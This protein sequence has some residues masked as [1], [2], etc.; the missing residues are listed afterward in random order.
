MPGHAASPYWT[1]VDFDSEDDDRSP[2]PNNNRM[3]LDPWDNDAMAKIP[4]GS[5]DS[6]QEPSNSFAG[7]PVSSSFY[8]VPTKN[9]DSSDEKPAKR[10]A[11][12]EDIIPEPSIYGRRA[13]RC[14]PPPDLQDVPVYA[15]RLVGEG[16]RSMYTEEPQFIPHPMVYE[17]M[18]GSVPMPPPGYLP[19]QRPR[20]SFVHHPDPMLANGYPN[21]RRHSRMVDAYEHYAYESLPQDYED[22]GHPMPQAAPNN[23]HLSRYRVTC[24]A[25]LERPTALKLK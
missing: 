5:P 1:A 6:S 9:Y 14:L 21:G 16:R 20:V 2:P 11:I 22:W 23:F 25:Q 15:Q 12:P 10:A 17:S 24:L 13:S 18:Y 19:V 4:G 7:E 3:Y 8:Y